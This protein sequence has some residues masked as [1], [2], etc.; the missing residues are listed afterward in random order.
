MNKTM[1]MMLMMTPTMMMTMTMTMT[2]K[3]IKMIKRKTL[4]IIGEGTNLKFGTNS[5]IDAQQGFLMKLTLLNPI[6]PL[7]SLN[8][9][10]HHH[11][12]H[13]LVHHI[14]GFTRRNLLE[15]RTF[16]DLF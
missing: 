8:Q 10:Q 13:H 6:H 14:K 7:Q 11:Q 15:S 1:M 4:K 5:K 16:Q 12:H 2:I 3:M 9:Q